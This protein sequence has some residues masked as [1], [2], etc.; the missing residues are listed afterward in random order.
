MARSIRSSSLES[1]TAR[2]KL[3]PRR[4]PYTVRVAPGVRL[5]YRR[6]QIGGGWNVIAAD[7]KGGNW[8]K[9]FARAD[10][11]EEANGDTV[12]NFWQAQ[13]RARV[14]ARGDGK[15][16]VTAE[17]TGA[18]VTVTAALDAYVA[19]LET[20]GGGTDNVA[21]VKL[22]LPTRLADKA[23]ALLSAREVKQWRDGLRKTGLA[24]GTVNRIGNALRAA[25]NLAANTD[26]RIA[27]RRAW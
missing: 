25:L 22:H 1:R 20:R 13:E 27:S 19:D 23:V 5:G 17:D 18:P 12:L 6:H 16:D 15:A 24:A 21:R 3:A 4:K 8:L 26:D 2:L 14:L 7:G 10:D 9:A 11:H